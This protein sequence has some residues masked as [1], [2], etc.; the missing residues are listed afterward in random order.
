MGIFVDAT[1]NYHLTK[2]SNLHT[3]FLLCRGHDIKFHFQTFLMYIICNI[4]NLG[5]PIQRKKGKG[6]KLRDE[7]QN[8]KENKKNNK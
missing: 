5:K 8:R 6:K 1:N 4:N 2:S 3:N 7:K